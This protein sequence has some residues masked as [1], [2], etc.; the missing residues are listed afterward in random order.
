MIANIITNNHIGKIVQLLLPNPKVLK[1]PS[2][3][4]KKCGFK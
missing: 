3:A 4:Y 2:F 1:E